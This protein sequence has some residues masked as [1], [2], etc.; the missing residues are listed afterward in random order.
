MVFSTGCSNV[1]IREP[2]HR[3]SATES[4]EPIIVDTDGAV[5]WDDG[6]ALAMLLQH[7]EKVEILGITTVIGNH[8]PYQAAEYVARILK[9][10]RRTEIPIYIGADAPLKNSAAQMKKLESALIRQQVVPKEGFWKGAYSRSKEVRS[11]EEIEPAQGEPLTG[12]RPQPKSAVDFITETLSRATR[13]ITIIAIGPLTNLAAALKKNPEISK[14]IRRIL[15]MGGNVRVPGNTTPN[16][17]LNFLFD[18][19]A[20]D[21]VLRSPIR[22]K[23][24]FPLD[25]SNQA[26]LN[27]ERYQDLVKI[28]TPYTLFLAADRGP[29]FSDPKY[30]IQSWDTTVTTY[31]VN[32]SY[33]LGSEELC[34]GVESKFGPR[35][36]EVREKMDCTNK[37]RVMTKMD[38]GQYF[39]ILKAS[40]ESQFQ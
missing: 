7:P 2:S 28:P 36:G 31:L 29:K 17:E 6:A 8:W 25:L 40:L 33:I 3:A 18:P 10:A 12:I 9:A 35:Y 34:L 1:S 16:A 27:Y 5:F 30:S 11:F 23:L 38:S 22:E 15:I 19:D 4:P 13:P 32:P 26:T 20:A 24:L 14:N 37:V 21:V 39:S